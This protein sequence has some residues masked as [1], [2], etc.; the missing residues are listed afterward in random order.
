MHAVGLN[1]LADHEWAFFTQYH[2]D[3]VELCIGIDYLVSLLAEAKLGRSISV[4]EKG[5]AVHA[6]TLYMA[7]S[8]NERGEVLGWFEEHWWVKFDW[9]LEVE[10]VHANGK[11]RYEGG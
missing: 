6:W 11:G 1:P 3:A 2:Q 5:R 10:G 4:E 9:R 7:L 8:P